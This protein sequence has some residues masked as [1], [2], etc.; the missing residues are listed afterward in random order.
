[1][2]LIIFLLICGTIW[3]IYKSGHY[4]FEMND[5]QRKKLER[6]IDKIA[7]FIGGKHE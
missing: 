3:F 4:L 1:M 6:T 7:I 2:F 5:E